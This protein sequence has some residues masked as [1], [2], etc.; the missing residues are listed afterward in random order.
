M[1]LSVRID[2]DDHE[3]LR[4]MSKKT[5]RPMTELVGDAI[6]ELKKKF[7]LEATVQ[8]YRKLQEDDA[9]WAQEQEEQDMWDSATSTD[10]DLKDWKD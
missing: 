1:A 10:V 2:A 5:H 6:A 4:L 8:G 3:S 7:I 9:V